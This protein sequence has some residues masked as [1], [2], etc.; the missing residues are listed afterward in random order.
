[1]FGASRWLEPLA[2]I[3]VSSGKLAAHSALTRAVVRI[4]MIVVS[5]V[6]RCLGR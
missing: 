4:F 1:M 5:S 3:G 2:T 6:L